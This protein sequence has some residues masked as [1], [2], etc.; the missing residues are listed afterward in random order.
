MTADL[1]S[2]LDRFW[3]VIAAGHLALAAIALHFGAVTLAGGSPM[4]PEVYGPAVYAV[5]ALAWAGGQAGAEL[6]AALG[7]ALRG[8]A[9]AVMLILSGCFILPTY[10]FLA[11]VANLTGEGVIV[12]AA[13]LYLTMPFSVFSIVVG[14]GG[15]NA[16]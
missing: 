15:L 5:P 3:P 2:W 1:R 9:G 8:R 14:I 12:A 7:A 11:A 13:C 16:R 10:G 4:T 6:L